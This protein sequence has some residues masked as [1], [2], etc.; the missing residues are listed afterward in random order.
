[1]QKNG[2]TV[3]LTD[4]QRVFVNSVLPAFLRDG[5]SLEQL[6]RMMSLFGLS[7]DDKLC[8]DADDDYTP[9]HPVWWPSSR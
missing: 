6:E 9:Y 4:D 8:H 3:C 5:M 1:M 2:D 7:V